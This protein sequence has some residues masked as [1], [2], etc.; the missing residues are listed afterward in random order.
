MTISQ[1]GSVITQTN[2]P[3]IAI[4]GVSS[5]ANGIRFTTAVAHGYSNGNF[6]QIKGTTDYNYAWRI[7]SST[8][9]TFD[10]TNQTK[11]IV[12]GGGQANYHVKVSD[13]F[14]TSQ[15]GTVERGD[16]DP[17]GL[18][19]LS[20]VTTISSNAMTIINT[21][22]NVIDIQGAWMWDGR[23]H[24]IL[25]GQGT[26]GV[27]VNG[28]GFLKLGRTLF[29][30]TELY[31]HVAHVYQ[32]TGVTTTPFDPG[33]FDTP[34]GAL[35]VDGP[36]ATLHWEDC[37]IQCMTF[38]GGP[39]FIAGNG[40]N[41]INNAN[42]YIEN[43]IWQTR[44]PYL[45]GWRTPNGYI[46]DSF[47]FS[48]STIIFSDAVAGNEPQGLSVAGAAS[49][50]FGQGAPLFQWRNL[51]VSN[52]A[53]VADLKLFTE[54]GTSFTEQYAINNSTGNNL[55]IKSDTP[56][57]DSRNKGRNL[58]IKELIANVQDQGGNGIDG[59]VVYTRDTNNG[60]RK[61]LNGFDDTADKSY[62]GSTTSGLTGTLSIITAIVNVAS[63]TSTPAGTDTNGGT[64]NSG[65]YRVDFRGKGD[66]TLPAANDAATQA[67][68]DETA[69]FDVMSFGYGYRVST[70][71]VLLSGIDVLTQTVV[72]LVDAG[73]TNPSKSAVDA[74]T[75]ILHVFN[76]GTLEIT[77]TQ[78]HSWNEVY[79]FIQ[80]VSADNPSEVWDNNKSEYAS[81]LNKQNYTFTN[82]SLT[83][84]GASLSC[85]EGQTLPTK[86]SVVSGGFFEDDDGAIWESAGSIFKA[87]RARIQVV[88]SVSSLPISGAAVGF[89]DE[90]TQ[91]VLSYDST[92]SKT[93]LVTDGSGQVDGYFVYQIDS[94]V[95]TQ[96][97]SV[98]TE[99]S[100]THLKTPRSLSGAPIGSSTASE[101]SRLSQDQE[102]SLSQTG[103]GAITGVSIAHS[104][105]LADLGD[106]TLSDSY[107]RIKFLQSSDADIEPG[108]PGC[109]SICIYGQILSKSGSNYTAISDWSY[110]NVGN[111]GAFFD[112][113]IIFDA[114]GVI[115]RSY[116]G[117]K[118]IFSVAGTYDFRGASINYNVELINSSGLAV[119]VLLSPSMTFTNTGPMITVTQS[120]PVD[121]TAP[122][123]IDGTRVL[124]TNTTQSSTIIDN[125]LVSGSAG[126]IYSGSLGPGQEF[127]DGDIL[128]L[129]IAWWSGV[130]AMIPIV[131]TVEV[132]T[133][134]ASFLGTQEVDTIHDSLGYNGSLIDKNA[135]PSTGEIS[136]DIG[137]VEIDADDPDGL[138]DSRKGIAWFRYITH[139]AAG[140]QGFD[141]EAI[142]YNPDER[143][144]LVHGNLK[145]DNVNSTPIKITDGIWVPENGDYIVA[146]TSNTV[147]WVPDDRVYQGKFQIVN[148]YSSDMIMS[149]KDDTV[150]A[151]IDDETTSL[152]VSDDE[153]SVSL[154][155]DSVSAADFN[156][157]VSVATVEE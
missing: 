42:I 151:N 38:G 122:N 27:Y 70:T 143:N 75:G 39:S 52:R 112:G 44:Q 61:N 131:T 111:T 103:A 120:I 101:V 116:S 7:E 62:Q 59:A 114:P 121:V 23:R 30:G 76:A 148:H 53:N 25:S 146:S 95:F 93:V 105:K 66:T 96:T 156:D 64:S 24:N 29:T 16:N 49:A 65:V 4:T 142:E 90:L 123:L 100:Y 141:I 137:N 154:E 54:F 124:L 127:E 138:F 115:S 129:R 3:A 12:P 155:D 19:G 9:T 126:Y 18:I 14:T 73:I 6:V 135:S 85:D 13:L 106:N 2:E 147:W 57:S 77:V 98:V 94:T 125:S 107:D 35:C 63:S 69:K 22:T 34:T 91:T 67:A 50:I 83:V 82:L 46:K 139:T 149:V 150:S 15:T 144:I 43:G 102:T 1:S 134:G 37:A 31:S 36:S 157:E 88:D 89:G 117:T 68:Y 58:V 110:S 51:D 133:S 119:T 5:I 48:G 72:N 153:V 99:Y 152:S 74:Y 140:I 136:A 132:T 113:S 26:L 17:S 80:S 78:N 55:K 84:N 60:Q 86:P 28:N 104:S 108:I 47:L 33:N 11:L 79:D 41:F 118:F 8:A 40:F 109:M 97:A 10:I 145:I 130:N 45:A 81:T 92:Q 32:N 21:G 71:S 87:S 20:G 128:E 56:G